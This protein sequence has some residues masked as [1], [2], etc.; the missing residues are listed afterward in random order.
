ME[1]GD[2]NESKVRNG[3]ISIDGAEDGCVD[4]DGEVVGDDDGCDDIVGLSAGDK[5]GLQSRSFRRGERGISYSAQ[6]HIISNA[7][8]KTH[9]NSEQSVPYQKD[10]N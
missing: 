5:G 7:H 2:A 9:K 8:Y 1:R 4:I 10:L 6:T 3:S